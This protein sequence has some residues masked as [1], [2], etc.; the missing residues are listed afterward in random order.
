V[1]VVMA[2]KYPIKPYAHAFFISVLVTIVSTVL[3]L[4]I[5]QHI[6]FTLFIVETIL[7]LFTQS[8]IS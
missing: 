5:I 2:V 3:E 6:V 7:L 8:S 4:I 1:F